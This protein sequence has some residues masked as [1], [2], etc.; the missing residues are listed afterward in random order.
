VLSEAL[1]ATGTFLSQIRR[2]RTV[3]V[4]DQSSKANAIALAGEYFSS[5]RPRLVEAIGETET[6]IAHDVCWQDLVR[7]AHGNNARRSYVS[8][9]KKLLRQL[10][11][12]SIAVHTRPTSDAPL[13][14]PSVTTLAEIRLIETL[15]RLVPSA[16]ASYRQAL[17]DL[18]D[19]TRLS[20]RGTA[21]EF[22]EALRETLD[23]LAPDN[24]V[25]AQP[26]Y[27]QEPGQSKPTMKQKV[28]FV[29]LSRDR[30]KTQRESAEKSVAF[31]SELSGEIA[32]AVY[33]RASLATHVQESRNEVARIKRYV[34]TV[35]VD[36][37][38][39]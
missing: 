15:E 6:V 26:N 5:T 19:A 8:A 37:L 35:L 16:A 33:N 11:E 12:F 29:L 31:V 18:A 34:D 24:A 10:N 30:N 39:V 32:R 22:R 4:N 38:E 20:Y 13:K 36:L 21:S 27:T 9:L 14:A 3:N 17:I 25:M 28:R 2:G 7:L 1:S 23:H